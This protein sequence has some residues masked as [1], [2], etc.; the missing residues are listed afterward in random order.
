MATQPAHR[1]WDQRPETFPC[2]DSRVSIDGPS[3]NLETLLSCPNG[4][5]VGAVA[6]ICHPHPLHGGTMQNKVV[7]YMAR[8]LG[9]LGLRT[10]RFNF[11]GVGAS[12]GSYAHGRGEQRDLQA[13]LEW[14]RER[15]PG[16]Q[17]WLAGFSFGCYVAMREAAESNDVQRLITIAPPVDSFDFSV[18]QTPRCPWLLLQ[19]EADEVV[20]APN[21]LRWA[22]SLEPRP[23]IVALPGVD[24]FFHRRLNLLREVLLDRL[25]EAADQLESRPG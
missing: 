12:D 14:V 17:V 6:V 24:H 2:T 10:V 16:D 21:V 11:R 13:V 15:A 1:P 4:A 8:T 18:L 7:H 5:G 19:G 22:R 23:D 3:G 9:E 20:S 25:R